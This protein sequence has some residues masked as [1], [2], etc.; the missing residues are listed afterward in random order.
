MNSKPARNTKI[1]YAPEMR[2]DAKNAT[3]GSTI[4]FA[5]V[6]IV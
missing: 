5:D 3:S 6:V 2:E 4:V 1:G